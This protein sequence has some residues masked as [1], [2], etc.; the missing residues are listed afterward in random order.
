[1]IKPRDETSITR[2]ILPID[3]LI[4][5]LTALNLSRA[6]LKKAKKIKGPFQTVEKSTITK[7]AKSAL[8]VLREYGSISVWLDFIIKTMVDTISTM[9]E[10]RRNSSNGIYVQ[11]CSFRRR[12]KRTTTERTNSIN[13]IRAK[14]TVIIVFAY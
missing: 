8:R 1:M 12:F 5:A 7:R 14:A 9:V 4:V 2:F 10:K 3:P 13:S 6:R 11:R